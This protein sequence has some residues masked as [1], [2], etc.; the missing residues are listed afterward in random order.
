MEVELKPLTNL[1]EN[2]ESD[3]NDLSTSSPRNRANRRLR[4][5][6]LETGVDNRFLS[7]SGEVDDVK[8]HV[9]R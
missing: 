3:S 9:S 5:H 8:S 1:S 2:D 4:N 7:I 6:F